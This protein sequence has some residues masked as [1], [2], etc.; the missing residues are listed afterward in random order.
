MN[1]SCEAVIA[2]LEHLANVPLGSL[3]DVLRQAWPPGGERE[4][5][6]RISSLQRE[7]VARA[8]SVRLAKARE[9]AALQPTMC[10]LVDEMILARPRLTK[11][12]A[13]EELAKTRSLAVGTVRNRYYA[14]RSH[15]SV[16]TA[17]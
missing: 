14:S 11:T 12:A 6:R 7:F 8:T 13:F 10:D 3:A 16:V 9:A 15:E 5:A 1:T 4:A 17:S 2:Q